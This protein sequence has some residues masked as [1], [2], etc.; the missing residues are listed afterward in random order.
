VEL[1]QSGATNGNGVA[2]KR[3]DFQYASNGQ[4]ARINRYADLAGT[5]SVASTTYAYGATGQLDKLS[6]TQGT[7]NLATYVY[8][9]DS[10]RRITGI[11]YTNQSTA[12]NA[13][14]DYQYDA[15]GEVTS[16]THT[17]Q[18]NENY[19][20][21]ANGNRTSVGSGSSA[22]AW[23]IGANNLV[24]SDGTYNYSYDGEGNMI[25]RTSIVTGD[26]TTYAWGN[27]KELLKVE[28][29]TAAGAV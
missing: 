16:A 9:Y 1:T 23:M 13:S 11:Q 15:D 4:Y 6:H 3:V 26:Y 17:D 27:D 10:Q 14:H 20:Y 24:L 28:T 18:T 22:H 8:T 29:V 7:T 25:R 12:S 19:A 21:D 2:V 5:Q